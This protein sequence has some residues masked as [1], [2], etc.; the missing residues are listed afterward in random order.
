MVSYK[1]YLHTKSKSD[2]LIF[3]LNIVA[4]PY[5]DGSDRLEIMDGKIREIQLQRQQ[6]T[7]VI[8]SPCDRAADLCFCFLLIAFKPGMKHDAASPKP[9]NAS[10]W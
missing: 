6:I 4:S 10:M 2:V 5:E 3:Y 8:I 9:V 1:R 7:D